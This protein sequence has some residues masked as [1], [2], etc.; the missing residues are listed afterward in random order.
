MTVQ[1]AQFDLLHQLVSLADMR[2]RVIG[3]NIANVN[4]PD[5]RRL[6]VSFE[7]TLSQLL[8]N[9]EDGLAKAVDPAILERGGGAMRADGNNVDIDREL[10]ALNRNSL[11]Y[12]TFVQVMSSRLSSMRS[13]I[14]GR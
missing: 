5:Y 13:A 14:T 10:G 7:E 11:L 4:T 12:Q 1:P 8:T 9:G 3:Q 2:Q 6:D